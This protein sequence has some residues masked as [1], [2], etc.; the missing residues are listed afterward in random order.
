MMRMPHLLRHAMTL[1]LACLLAG[2][3]AGCTSIHITDREGHTR[4][5][6]SLGLTR[7]VL[8]AEADAWLW[9]T[10]ALGLHGDPQRFV[11]GYLD[12]ETATLSNQCRLVIWANSA[13]DLQAWQAHLATMDRACV[14][15]TAIKEE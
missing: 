2:L 14:L 15:T 8:P 1:S 10:R 13:T 9:R 4:V 11:L 6:R 7:I 3:M 5:E 12:E